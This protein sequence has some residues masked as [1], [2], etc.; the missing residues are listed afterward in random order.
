[1]TLEHGGSSGRERV[2]ARGWSS[3]PPNHGRRGGARHGV[4]VKPR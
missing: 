4:P 2:S 3:R 1:M